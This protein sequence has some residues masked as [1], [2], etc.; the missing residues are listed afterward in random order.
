LPT[1][2]PPIPVPGTKNQT[3]Y[4]HSKQHCLFLKA[5]F[6]RQIKEMALAVRTNHLAKLKTELLTEQAL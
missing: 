1:L 4:L 5:H 6:K 3:S 2:E